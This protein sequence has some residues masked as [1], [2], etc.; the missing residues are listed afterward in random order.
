M[1]ELEPQLTPLTAEPP[2]KRWP[3]ASQALTLVA[4]GLILGIGGCAAFVASINSKSS[5]P[6]V[7][8]AIFFVGLLAVFLGCVEVLILTFRAILGRH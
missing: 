7:F 5:L 4:A 1:S 6:M 2:R 8:G 3:S